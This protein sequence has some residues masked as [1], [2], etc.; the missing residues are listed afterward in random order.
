MKTQS[1]LCKF[2][3]LKRIEVRDIINLIV[4]ITGI[5]ISN[6]ELLQLRKFLVNGSQRFIIYNIILSVIMILMF[7]YGVR[8]RIENIINIMNVK[9]LLLVYMEQCIS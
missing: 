8:N 4:F 2:E 6:V 3:I 9:K 1:N 5:V 7:I